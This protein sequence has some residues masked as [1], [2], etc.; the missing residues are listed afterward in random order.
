[1]TDNEENEKNVNGTEKFRHETIEIGNGKSPSGSKRTVSRRTMIAAVLLVVGITIGWLGA[2]QL[3][4][5]QGTDI[6]GL[7]VSGADIGAEAAAA[8][9]VDYIA[10]RLEQSYPGIDVVADSFGESEDIPGTYEV[11]IT[12]TFQGQPQS[13]PYY[14]TKDGSW[15]FGGLLGLD[16]APP[17]AAP[18]APSGSG[19]GGSDREVDMVAVMDDDA[20]KGDPNAPVIMVEFS[21][22]ECPFCTRFYTQTLPAITE[23]YIDT[24]KVKFVYRDFPL[25]FHPNAQKAGE[26]AECADDQDKFWEMH[27]I[28]FENG[29][30]GG[31]DTFKGYAADLGL[32]TDAFDECLDSGKYADEVQK[33]LADGSALGVSGTPAFFINGV[34]ISGAQPFEVFQQVIEQELGGG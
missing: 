28:L 14:V 1:M 4:Q 12:M 18:T 24:G 20:V 9:V 31:S 29:V 30:A 10:V 27:D 19:T 15:M 32:D 34:F 26:A 16:E 3:N 6:T 13:A 7:A 23:Q 33:D 11:M 17:E 21:D 8:K 22:F 5:A 25:N 2:S